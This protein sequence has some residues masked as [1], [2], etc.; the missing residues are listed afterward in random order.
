MEEPQS[1]SNAK[2]AL[3][4]D[5]AHH[6]V[7]LPIALI[8][9]IWSCINL[10]TALRDGQSVAMYALLFGI[11]LG[12]LLAVLKMRVYATKTQD[13]IVRVE[14]QF[15]HF[16]L[17]GKELNPKLTL[18]QIIALRYAGDNEL[19]ALAERTASENLQP[20]AIQAAIKNRRV[21]TMRI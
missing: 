6:F 17:T 3:R 2:Q 7:N 18:A 21:D 12:L 16:R 13:R 19:P 20:A 15:R 14:E 4:F 5:P 1:Q 8:V 10:F 11:T 9:F